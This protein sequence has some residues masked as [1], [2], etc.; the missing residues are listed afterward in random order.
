MD[1][2]PQPILEIAAGFMASKQLFVASRIGL[3]A[4]LGAG[5][6]SLDELARR[7]GTP[8]RTTRILADAMT[9]L[10]LLE[11]HGEV[12]ANTPATGAF[13]SGLTPMDLRPLLRFWDQLSYPAWTGLERAVRTGEGVAFTLSDE[14][15]RLV[16]EG[17]EAIT[18]GAA[19]ALAGAVP[20]GDHRRVLDIGGGTGSFLS[21]LLAFYPALSGT[22]FES[23]RVAALTREKVAPLSG[24]IEVVAGDF[25]VDALPEG[26]DCLIAANVLHLSGPEKNLDLLRRMRHAVRPKDRALLIDFWTDATHTDPVFAALMA[27]EFLIVSGEGDVYSVDELR[28]WLDQ[29]GWRLLEHRPLA[30]PSSLVIAEAT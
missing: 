27:G 7:C 5:P 12:Y 2:T 8:R 10:D 21:M 29:T 14:Q 15:G 4:A 24:R 26:H 19:M 13:L 25:H 22:V 20:F 16:S 17:I 11:R 30:G 1:L 3:F 28:S 9:A 18:A 23:P 6:A